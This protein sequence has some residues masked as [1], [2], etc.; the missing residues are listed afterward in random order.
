MRL[1]VERSGVMRDA[2]SAY[3]MHMKRL[4][5]YKYVVLKILLLMTKIS[6]IL[7]IKTITSPWILNNKPKSSTKSDQLKIT[8]QDH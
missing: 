1:E 6:S 4:L 2:W 7:N 5:S 8:S 3:I